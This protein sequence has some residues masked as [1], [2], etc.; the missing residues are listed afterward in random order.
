MK[1]RIAVF[2]ML[3]ILVFPGCSLIDN[4]GD[5]IGNPDFV[6]SFEHVNIET[7]ITSYMDNLAKVNLPSDYTLVEGDSYWD[8]VYLINDK[9]TIE[10]DNGFLI[11]SFATDDIGSDI[12]EML[13]YVEAMTLT[14]EPETPPENFGSTVNE[15][16][17]LEQFGTDI[18]WS[19][20]SYFG[21]TVRYEFYQNEDGI[22][23]LH[24]EDTKMGH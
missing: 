4:Q 16:N 17:Q 6:P 15:Y 19:D 2:I 23:Q 9:H 3:I 24:A 14:L 21:D 12:G 18:S 8:A 11:I 7:F 13:H 1:S 5:I 22:Y 20:L 10:Y